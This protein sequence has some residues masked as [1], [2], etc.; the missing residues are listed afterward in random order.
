MIKRRD[1]AKKD[2]KGFS[3]GF[4]AV[5]VDLMIL[6]VTIYVYLITPILTRKMKYENVIVTPQ[7]R[8][9]HPYFLY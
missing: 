3:K 1:K 2:S 8:H 6:A 4:F 9:R 5:K 7:N